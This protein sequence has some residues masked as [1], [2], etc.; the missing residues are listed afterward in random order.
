MLLSR[1]VN[2]FSEYGIM[3]Q[4]PLVISI[5]SEYGNA[6]QLFRAVNIHNI[7]RLSMVIRCKTLALSVPSVESGSTWY[8]TLLYCE[9]PQ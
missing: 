1:I 3:L 2:T 4:L 8:L 5:F 7:G 9:H 6:L